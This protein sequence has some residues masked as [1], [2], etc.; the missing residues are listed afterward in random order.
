MCGPPLTPSHLLKR[1]QAAGE[2]EV[3]VLQAKKEAVENVR[4]RFR[5]KPVKRPSLA[6]NA[7][8]ALEPQPR[9]PAGG[10][11]QAT[12]QTRKDKN[13][14]GVRFCGGCSTWVEVRHAF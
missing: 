13:E 12:A 10:R 9:R 1:R 6:A 3:N 2:K 11:W 4:G 14:H 8:D 7:S 5:R